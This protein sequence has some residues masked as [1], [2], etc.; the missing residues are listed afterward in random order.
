MSVSSRQALRVRGCETCRLSSAG[1]GTAWIGV[2]GTT[3]G[4]SAVVGDSPVRE[5]TGSVVGVFSSSSEPVKFAVNLAGPPVK[6]KYYLVTDSGQ[7]P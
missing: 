3:L 1:D 7:V 6:P 5:S 2:S 4:W